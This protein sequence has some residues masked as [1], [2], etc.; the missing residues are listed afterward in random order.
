MSIVFW[1]F[2]R[3]NLLLC[4]I[5]PVNSNLESSAHFLMESTFPVR[6]T[7]NFFPDCKLDVSS[8]PPVTE[9]YYNNS[10]NM[11]TCG[12][13]LASSHANRKK[14]ADRPTRTCG[15]VPLFMY[16]VWVCETVILIYSIKAFLHNL[17]WI[18][19][20]PNYLN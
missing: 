5:P 4:P 17:M 2:L 11:E 14:F 15:L 1:Q 12:N 7:K 16:Y 20:K 13:V 9:W 8:H 10:L 18:Y 3:D 19:C 6:V